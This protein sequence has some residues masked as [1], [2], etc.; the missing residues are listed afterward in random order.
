MGITTIIDS[1]E[2]IAFHQVEGVLTFEE[3]AAAIEGL[4]SSPDFNTE[5]NIIAEIMPGSTSALGSDDIHRIVKLTRNLNNRTGP[6]RTV[7]IV[8]ND[9]DFGIFHVLEF[10]LKNE[11]RELRVFRSMSEG[12]DWLNDQHNQD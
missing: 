10:L 9:A 3:I 8:S 4:F 2:G 1:K 5:M 6:G 12:K 7:I 11:G